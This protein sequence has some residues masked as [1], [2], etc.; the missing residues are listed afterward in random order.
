MKKRAFH[1]VN[2]CG[3]LEIKIV[4]R[5]EAKREKNENADVYTR[6]IIYYGHDVLLYKN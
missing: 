5:K 2:E 1:I 3:G 6:Y 4:G